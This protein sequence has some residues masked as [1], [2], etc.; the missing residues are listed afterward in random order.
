M[1]LNLLKVVRSHL[2]VTE[3]SGLHL[4]P[5]PD[6]SLLLA[7]LAPALWVLPPP[8]EVR[9]TADPGTSAAPAGARDR[10]PLAAAASACLRSPCL[11]IQSRLPSKANSSFFSFLKRTYCKRKLDIIPKYEKPRTGCREQEAPEE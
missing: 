6:D 8:L 7:P 3:R 2:E 5:G 1:A 4:P 9:R 10:L 11:I